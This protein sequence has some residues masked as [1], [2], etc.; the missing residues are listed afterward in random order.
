M[1]HV[2]R[3]LYD[4]EFINAGC[5]I[6]DFDPNTSFDTTVGTYLT[7]YV[8]T[9]TCIYVA[10]QYFRK[11][12]GRKGHMF[13]FLILM[14]VSFG[15]AGVNHQ[16][17]RRKDD[18]RKVWLERIAFFFVAAA[19]VVLLDFGMKIIESIVTLTWIQTIRLVLSIALSAITIGFTLVTT[20]TVVIGVMALLVYT[21]MIAVYSWLLCKVDRGTGRLL[22]GLKIAG[23]ITMICGSLIQLMFME[24]CDSETAYKSCFS[25]CPFPY[26]TVFNSNG[27]FHVVFNV[28]VLVFAVSEGQ[29]AE[30]SQYQPVPEAMV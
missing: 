14:A 20:N 4:N 24:S 9:L 13:Y 3:I 25:T 15:I 8:M 18:I 7:N 27:L 22:N 19:N 6:E 1:S 30:E 26:P 5:P 16:F 23:L 2:S 28:G 10:M 17:S 21:I 12:N 29:M 11:E